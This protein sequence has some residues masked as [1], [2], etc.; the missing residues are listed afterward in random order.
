MALTTN[1][2]AR[3][4]TTECDTNAQVISHESTEHTKP[5][6]MTYRP[7]LDLYDLEDAYELYVDLPGTTSDDI[8][9]VVHDGVLTIEA[10]VGARHSDG[11]EPM[12]VEY[13]V[14]NYRRRLRLGEDIDGDGM[15]ASYASGVLI[16]RLPKRSERQPRRVEVRPG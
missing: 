16:L 8:D 1:T 13:G 12:H 10:N 15:V 7:S 14:G 3:C 4:A 5:R 2:G 9:V 11:I 6:D